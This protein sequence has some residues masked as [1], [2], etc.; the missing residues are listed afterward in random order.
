MINKLLASVG[1]QVVNGILTKNNAK[2][3]TAVG[4][5]AIGA[6]ATPPYFSGVVPPEYEV[7]LRLAIAVIGVIAFVV[8]KR[9]A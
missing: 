5:V 3:S 6:A 2:P 9:K 8:E 4:T 7:W 1:L